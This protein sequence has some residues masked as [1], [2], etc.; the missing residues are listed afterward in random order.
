MRL[1]E[2]GALITTFQV[3][4][5]VCVIADCARTYFCHCT[6][7]DYTFRV[8]AFL[9]LYTTSVAVELSVARSTLT[10]VGYPFVVS[11]VVT[12]NRNLPSW[13]YGSMPPG[14]VGEACRS[15]VASLHGFLAYGVAVEGVVALWRSW[16]YNYRLLVW[17]TVVFASFGLLITVAGDSPALQRMRVVISAAG[18][19]YP[20]IVAA[21]TLEPRRYERAVQ[22]SRG[23]VVFAT[24]E[25]SE[26]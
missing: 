7:D 23:K 1:E 25:T 24:L 11:M 21:A 14:C 19:V 12:T 20:R 22:S 8:P 13:V 16:R 9:C 4:G 3:V 26:L 6:E 17:L 2:A 10:L 15:D 18:L 5:V